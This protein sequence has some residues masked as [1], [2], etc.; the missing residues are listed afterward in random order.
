ME[1]IEDNNLQ[2]QIAESR[3]ALARKVTDLQLWLGKNPNHHH[4]ERKKNEWNEA[5]GELRRANDENKNRGH[6]QEIGIGRVLKESVSKEVYGKA[7][8]E[9]NNRRNGGAPKIV[10]VISDADWEIIEKYKPLENK[11]N[12]IRSKINSLV[13]ELDNKLIPTTGS[14]SPEQ[15]NNI[16]NINKHILKIKNELSIITI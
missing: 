11:Y 14:H 5:M 10:S 12:S 3:N 4:Y 1:T 15:W 9:W 16:Q 6:E 2:K 8:Q 7:R 13:K